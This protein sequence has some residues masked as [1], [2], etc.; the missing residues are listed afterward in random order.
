MAERQRPA[1]LDFL[2]KSGAGKALQRLNTWLYL[3][4]D[5]KLGGTFRSAPVCLLTTIGRKSGEPR[6]VPLLYLRDGDK[7]ILVASKGGWDHH[8][9]WY[10]NL[11]ARP[12]VE[13]QIDGETLAMTA[14]DAPDAARATYWP[15]L[16]DMYPDFRRYQSWT[17]RTIPVVVLR[18]HR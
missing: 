10:L 3:K 8:P 6:T 5:G 2:F 16:V 15:K 11:Q 13:V 18:P 17:D 14:E 12:E 9:L 7:V 4:T 1:M